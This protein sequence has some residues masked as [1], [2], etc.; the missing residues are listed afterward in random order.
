MVHSRNKFLNTDGI[1]KKDNKQSSGD[2]ALMGIVRATTL[3][4]S[5]RLDKLQELLTTIQE[6]KTYHFWSENSFSAHEL[7]LHLLRLTGPAKVYIATWTI[8]E[9]VGRDIL[10]AIECGLITE[11]VGVL[12][13]TSEGRH[14]ADFHFSKSLFKRLSTT[15]VHAKCAVIENDKFLISFFGSSNFTTNQR[16]ERGLLNTVHMVAR[17]DKETILRL[18]EEGDPVL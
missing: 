12:D 1:L 18:M 8:S 13:K 11:M 10:E 17:Q 6:E 5:K 15:N 4:E 14:P 3:F 9:K 2:N 16:I 7:L